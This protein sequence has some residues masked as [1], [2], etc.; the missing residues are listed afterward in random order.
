MAKKDIV[1]KKKN[2]V[3]REAQIE[4]INNNDTKLKIIAT[5]LT[6]IVVAIGGLYYY[7]ND[8]KDTTNDSIDMVKF[9]KEYEEYNG[10][11]TPYGGNYLEIDIAKEK[12]I[13]HMMKF[14]LY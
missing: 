8:D 5:V 6:L 12:N 10:K 1:K 3:I 9:E 4:G 11:E 14:I 7:F 2:E 13:H